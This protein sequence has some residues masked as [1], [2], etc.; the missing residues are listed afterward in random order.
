MKKKKSSLAVSHVISELEKLAPSGTSEKWDNTG[1]LAGD[2]EWK[3]AGAV[4]SVDLTEQAIE[5]ALKRGYKLIVNHHPCI[6]P[7]SRGLARVVPGPRS[8]ISSLVFE[9]IRNGIAVASYHTN[10]DQ[11]SLEVVRTVA[12]GLGVQ[13]RGRFLESGESPLLKLVVFVPATHAEIVRDALGQAGAGH[14]GNYDFCTFGTAGEGTF[15]GSE[16]TR[17]FVGKPGHLEKVQEVRLET[18][19]PRG[20]KKSVLAAMRS[21]HPYEEIAYDL[22]RLEQEPS[23]LGLVRGLG[24]GFWGDFPS[25][26][27][28][29]EV[30][31]SVTEWFNTNG[32]LITGPGSGKAPK[33]I[34]RLGFVAG[35][36]ASFL[37][38]ASAAGC[39]LFI[40][41]EAGYHPALDG[42][43][44]G[45][46]VMELGH[47]ESEV[48]FIRTMESWLSGMGLN[49]IGL[50]LKT[51]SI[52]TASPPLA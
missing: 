16:Q 50:N 6:F 20:L 3:T 32:F 19:F 12:E 52:V 5:T 44:K 48:F 1:L 33:T 29:S 15:R 38:S 47:R 13:P 11:C 40:T 45:M 2:P 34:K 43:R 26:K 36:G 4:V 37:D 18:V 21:A 31:R 14:I 22:Y 46:A 17:P 39:E 35:K 8:G 9:A 42:S 30:V 23:L 51:Q 41:G 27:P 24:Y 28:F 49:T 25:P 10:F 7:K